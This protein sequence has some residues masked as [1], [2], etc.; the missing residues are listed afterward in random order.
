MFTESND[1]F[2]ERDDC[3]VCRWRNTPMC[4]VNSDYVGRQLSDVTRSIAVNNICHRFVASQEEQERRWQM[5][6]SKMQQNIFNG[7]S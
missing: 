1:A 7:G 5:T 4:P 3:V 6:M 2:K